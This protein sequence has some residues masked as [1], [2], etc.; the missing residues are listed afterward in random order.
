M[1]GA[2]SRGTLVR[3]ANYQRNGLK[4]YVH[5]LKKFGIGPTIDGPYTM[6]NQVQQQ[7]SQAILRKTG[8]SIGGKAHVKGHV[9]AKKDATSGETGEVPVSRTC[10]RR[11]PEWNPYAN[12]HP[13]HRR[14]DQLGIPR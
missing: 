6:V 8:K 9:L 10:P 1:A 11:A 14:R 7:G 3:N 2:L 12:N 4:S 5:A 13:G